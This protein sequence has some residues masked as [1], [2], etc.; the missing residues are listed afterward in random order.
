MSKLKLYIFDPRTIQILVALLPFLLIVALVK[1]FGVNVPVTDQYALVPLFKKIDA[2]TLGFRDIWA[3]HNEHRI[4]FPRIVLL[5]LA[6]LTHWSIKA[7]V[8]T[9]L[10]IAA[11]GYYALFLILQRLPYG[12]KTR[13]FVIGATSLW[14]FSPVQW[15]NWLWGWQVEWFMCVTASLWALYLLFSVAPKPKPGPKLIVA[16][17]FG[18]IATFSL[19]SGPII[20]IVGLTTL[21]LR[22]MHKSQIYFWILCSVLSIGLY[23]V[24]YKNPPLR[25]TTRDQLVLFVHKPMQF[26]SAYLAYIGRPIAAEPY[27]AMLSGSM[28]IAIFLVVMAILY[29]KRLFKEYSVLVGMALYTLIAGMLTTISRLDFGV[30]GGLSSRYTALSN[31]FVIS[32]VAIITGILTTHIRTLTK[33]VSELAIIVSIA[34]LML[35]AVASSYFNGYKGMVARSGLYHYIYNCSRDDNPTDAC[36]YQIYFPSISEA[37]D[38]LNYLKNK[39]YGGY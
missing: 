28:L 34:V 8:A 30:A 26:V 2:G 27:A 21:G 10:L 12:E 6:S 25:P 3:Q 14:Y 33:S 13:L 38:M 23:T 37:R 11:A 35:P 17:I 16:A 4:V 19:G 31:L 5:T 22:K 7:E 9:S 15:E 39:H 20:W 18:F 1:H 24:G 36:L 32:L 29:K